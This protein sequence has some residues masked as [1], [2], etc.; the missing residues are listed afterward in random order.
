[1]DTQSSTTR[2]AVVSETAPDPCSVDAF[3]AMLGHELRNPLAAITTGLTLLRSAPGDQHEW[4]KDSLERQ[5]RELCR[6]VDDLLDISRITRGKIK[7]QSENVD[8]QHTVDRAVEAVADLMAEKGHTLTVTRSSAPLVL[9]GDSSRLQQIV[10]QLLH[11]A[12]KYTADGGHIELIAERQG[13][14]AVVRVRDNGLG[15]PPE[16][17]TSIFELFGQVESGAHRTLEGLRIGLT[18]SRM[19]VQLHGG[20]VGVASEG[21]GKG[22]EFW[23]RLPLVPASEPV[24]RDEESSHES[25]PNSGLEVLVVEDNRDAVKMLAMMLEQ[26][27]H[28][29]RVA[30]DGFQALRLAAQRKTDVIILDIG[31]PGMSGYQVAESLRRELELNDSLILAVTGYVHEEDRL[32]SRQAGIDYHLVKP[33]EYETLAAVI[34]TW[35]KSGRKRPL[36]DAP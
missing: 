20:S 27:G 17:Q 8:L 30:E 4:I 25:G 5:T 19:L 24:A 35:Q 15:I 22:S 33:V 26:Q 2:T 34:R 23:V 14:D 36:E 11:H 18:L 3:L 13:T 10:A 16:M 9:H 7:L 1:M 12:A 31:L 21:L 32:R 29:V 6:L 28:R